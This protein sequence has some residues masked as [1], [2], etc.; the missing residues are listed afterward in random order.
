MLGVLYGFHREFV[1]PWNESNRVWKATCIREV[2]PFGLRW[3]WQSCLTGYFWVAG[4]SGLSL[5]PYPCR[6]A[7]MQRMKFTSN[8]KVHR[9]WLLTKTASMTRQER[10]WFHFQ[11]TS[12]I[13]FHRLNFRRLHSTPK[14]L[15]TS[16]FD[17]TLSI[18]FEW[19]LESEQLLALILDSECWTGLHSISLIYNFKIEHF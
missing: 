3:F 10:R 4:F 7:C 16:N 1:Y 15:S 2:E 6:I 5:L 11:A 14:Q 12:N 18:S 17:K 8:M 13:G 9:F 19:D